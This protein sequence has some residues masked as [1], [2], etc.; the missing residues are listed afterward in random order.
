MGFV[1]GNNSFEINPAYQI[2]KTITGGMPAINNAANANVSTLSGYG[3]DISSGAKSLTNINAGLNI[4]TLTAAQPINPFTQQNVT[5]A[6][7]G[8]GNSLASQNALIAA[9]QGNNPILG[10]S[11]ILGGVTGQAGNL[12]NLNAADNMHN[13]MWAQGNLQSALQQANGVNAQQSAL[14]NLGSVYGQQ[15]LTAN[16]LQNIAAGRGPNPAQAMLAQQTGQNVAN[17]AALMAGQRGAGAN[18]GLLAR[19][20]AQQGAATQ[21]QAV[22]QGATMQAQQSLGALGQL[23]GQQQAMAGTAGQMA[24]VGAGLTGQQQNALSQ[25]YGQGAQAASLLQGQQGLQANIAQQ[26][27]GN[28]LGAQATGVQSNLANTGQQLGALGQYN[29]NTVAAQNALL[30]AQSAQN[31]IAMQGR[32]GLL[33]T[34]LSSIPTWAPLAG[35]ALGSLFGGGGGSTAM[36]G[37]DTSDLGDI[38]SL[39]AR[40]GMVKGK[41]MATGGPVN[42][43]PPD[44]QA[45]SQQISGTMMPDASQF[46]APM[47]QPPMVAG[48][49]SAL[50]QYLKAG[51]ITGN[52]RQDQGQKMAQGGSARDFRGGGTVAASKP[53]EKAEKKGNSYSN[54]KIPAMLSEGEIVLPRSVTM[55]K[56]PIRGSA[57]FVR[58]VLAKRRAS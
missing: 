23:T 48:P 7:Q 16:Q 27:V 49:Q 33:N 45:P 6:Q 36:A 1:S 31:Q 22:G 50:G 13:A 44:Q 25:Q 57:E 30:A 55:G 8:V 37:A 58:K 34:G 52:I 39:A 19:Q 10:Q 26:Q 28:L 29:A 3:G 47:V 21:Q 2:D 11:N 17:Q 38:G 40:G 9:L 12:Q 14:G 46:S 18:V 56:D 53:V 51:N 24:G 15:Q 4:P 20:A 42:T 41:K 43:L 35:G 32:Q 54:D 5:G